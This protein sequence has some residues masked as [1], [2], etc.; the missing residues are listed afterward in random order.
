MRPIP[1]LL[2]STALCAA[3]LP[4]VAIGQDSGSVETV[5]YTHLTLPTK[6][7]V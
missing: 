7:I 6:R 5:S 2:A 3:L 4:A 1:L